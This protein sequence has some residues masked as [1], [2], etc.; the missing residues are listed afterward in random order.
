[1]ATHRGS[2]GLLTRVADGLLDRVFPARPKLGDAAGMRVASNIRAVLKKIG[3]II[4][5][6]SINSPREKFLN[7]T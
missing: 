4:H 5:F 1:M 3:E 2:N 6:F 7:A